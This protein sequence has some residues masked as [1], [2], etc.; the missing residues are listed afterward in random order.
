MTMFTTVLARVVVVAGVLT[1]G[2]VTVLPA[3][4]PSG[5]PEPG[6]AELLSEL[7]ALRAEVNQAAGASMRMQLRWRD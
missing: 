6:V 2:S 3:Q 4:A 7:R 1:I 5:S